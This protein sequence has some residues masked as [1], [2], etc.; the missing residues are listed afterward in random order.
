VIE[1]AIFGIADPDLPIHYATFMGATMM[2]KG[3]LLLNSR[4]V[5]HF[6]SKKTKSPVLGQNLT[7]LGDKYG[8]KIK[9]KFYNLKKAHPCVISRLLSYR[10]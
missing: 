4:I 3:S 1:S 10:A 8:S 9:L 6:R 5:K 2:I 7:V